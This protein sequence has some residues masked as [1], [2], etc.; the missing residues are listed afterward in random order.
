MMDDVFYKFLNDST[1]LDD[2]SV[3]QY[4]LDICNAKDDLLKIFKPHFT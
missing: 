2:V 3:R 4:E 1:G